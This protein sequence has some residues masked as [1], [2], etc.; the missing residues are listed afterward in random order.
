[1][2][3]P[4]ISLA[5]RA[6]DVAP[7]INIFEN[8]LMNAQRRD[9]AAAQEARQAEL[10]PFR[11]EQAQ[12]EQGMARNQQRLLN[13]HQTGQRLKPL[14]EAGDTD[15]AQRFLAN[16]ILEI[17]GRA[18][19]G[20]PENTN[21][22]VEILAKIRQG[23][24]QG[25]LGDINAVAGLVNQAAGRGPTAQQREFNE[26]SIIAQGDP[27]SDT[28]K[29]A[30][31]KL[32]LDPRAVGSA[33]Q[34][35]F[36]AGTT[37]EVAEAGK[38]LAKAGE[39][40]KLEAQRKLRP[41]IESAVKL[42]VAK[43]VQAADISKEQRSN[44]KAL[45]VYNVGIKGLTEALSKTVTGP[46]MGRFFAL[47]NNQQAAD[48]AVAA[49]APILK[50]MFRSAGEGN[51]TDSD[52]KLLLDMIPTRADGPEA[53]ESKLKNIDLIVKAKL[54]V[55]QEQQPAQS[56]KTTPAQPERQDGQIM[57]DAAG[58]RAMVYPDGS[59]KELP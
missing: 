20:S 40:G 4:R 58:N 57:V 37:E 25:A 3:D 13:I 41:E 22:S 38:I 2:I 7:A 19:Q 39:E 26:L 52:Q 42:A 50:Q 59:F 34:T 23:D 16:N 30:R 53:I 36:E 17:Q 56:K 12:R 9:I 8:A 44:Q 55:V 10:Q 46:V 18:A 35:T 5:V 6:P 48:G 32:G 21:D 29:A 45:D 28:T 15:A 47:S 54:G 51:F 49:M 1:M 11:V 24:I 43:S 14:L 27:K 33:A 31:I